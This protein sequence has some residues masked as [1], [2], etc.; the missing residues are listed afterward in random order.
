MLRKQDRGRK[1]REKNEEILNA[2][3]ELWGGCFHCLD[4]LVQGSNEG[5]GE[6]GEV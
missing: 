3:K 6:G 1:L 2:L 4:L 5:T